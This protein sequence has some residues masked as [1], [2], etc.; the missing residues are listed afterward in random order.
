MEQFI[1]LKI[2]KLKKKLS[3]IGKITLKRKLLK[4]DIQ[5][6]FLMGGDLQ[7]VDIKNI[8]KPNTPVMLT[9]RL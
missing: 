3:L 6:L 9:Q 4:R 2:K 8:T 5:I 7:R 1:N